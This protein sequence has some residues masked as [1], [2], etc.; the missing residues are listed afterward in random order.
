[1]TI[2]TLLHRR[3]NALSWE[4][5]NSKSTKTICGC[6]LRAQ[7]VIHNKRSQTPPSGRFPRRAEAK[8]GDNQCRAEC[9]TVRAENRAVID[10]HR[11][12]R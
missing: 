3:G 2:A 10:G 5:I 7:S 8:R 9:S 4:T 12:Q 11:Q 1:M 6:L